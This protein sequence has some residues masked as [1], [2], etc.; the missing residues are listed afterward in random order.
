MRKA[1]L[2]RIGYAFCSLCM[3]QQR[4]K[5]ISWDWCFA[6]V[7]RCNI[8]RVPLLDA[9]PICNE[10]DPI[11]F[12]SSISVSVPTCCSCGSDLSDGTDLPNLSISHES[13]DVVQD[14]YRTGLLGF[15]P[16]SPLLG[17]F[18]NHAFRQFVDDMLQTL[19][20][21]LNP[22][23]GPTRYCRQLHRSYATPQAAVDNSRACIEC[24]A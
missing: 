4:V 13:I 12:E 16:D 24:C 17:H 23:P 7:V 18:T 1:A 3:S 21:S 14:A 5:H 9:C 8:H 2:R 22:Q 19:I 10:L 6:C 15:A 20:E 11:S